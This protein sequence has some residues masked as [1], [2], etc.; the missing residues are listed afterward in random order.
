LAIGLVLGVATSPFNPK[1]K[2]WQHVVLHVCAF[3][4]LWPVLVLVAIPVAL[5]WYIRRWRS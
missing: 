4:F 3:I 5:R 2:G 1:E